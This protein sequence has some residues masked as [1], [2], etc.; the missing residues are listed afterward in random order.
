MILQYGLVNCD[1]WYYNGEEYL[2]NFEADKNM[3]LTWEFLPYYQIRIAFDAD[4]SVIEAYYDLEHEYTDNDYEGK[5]I[6]TAIELNGGAFDPDADTCDVLITFSDSGMYLG[7]VEIS[8]NE[9]IFC[10]THPWGETYLNENGEMYTNKLMELSPEMTVDEVKTLFGEPKYE[11]DS[12][13]DVDAL[14]WE[15]NQMLAQYGIVDCD[16]LYYAENDDFEYVNIR[17]AFD[18]EGAL[19]EAYYDAVAT[20]PT[21]VLEDGEEK[22]VVFV[23]FCDGDFDKTKKEVNVIMVFDDG[24]TYFGCATVTKRNVYFSTYYTLTT[25][26]GSVTLDSDGMIYNSEY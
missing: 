10:L 9:P 2:Q 12:Y 24:C 13:L 26:Y 18:K 20:Y 17:I 6:T 15:K 23:K 8:G 22:N 19:A 21:F 7:T 16:F 5:K 3:D 1:F 4:G 11:D 25:S 14:N